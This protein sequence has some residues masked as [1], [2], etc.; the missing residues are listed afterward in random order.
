LVFPPI[1]ISKGRESLKVK[2]KVY[3]E[4]TILLG[5][6]RK[7]P[8]QA[9]CNLSLYL[10]EDCGEEIGRKP[11]LSVSKESSHRQK[12]AMLG[13]GRVRKERNLKW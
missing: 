1:K 13:M 6:K 11:G 7:T 4:R 8:R 9:R 10:E 5:F 12:V 2:Q 3:S